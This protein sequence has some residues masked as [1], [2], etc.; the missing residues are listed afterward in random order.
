MI[1]ER[2]RMLRKGKGITQKELAD[3]L[4]VK[5]SSM[6]LYEIGKIDPPDEI[7]IAIAKYFNI[8]ADYLIGIIDIEVPYY[9]EDIFNNEDIFIKLP[10][11]VSL[12][13]KALIREFMKFIACRRKFQDI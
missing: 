10:P 7:K 3:I 4:G 13:E 2:L 12:E 1:G 6:S 9:N 8:S 11:N 5:K